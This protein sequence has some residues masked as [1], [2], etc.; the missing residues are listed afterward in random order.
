MPRAGAPL[1]C[2]P[3]PCPSLRGAISTPS[4]PDQKRRARSG[5]SAG[6]SMSASGMAA[7]ATPPPPG[8]LRRVRVLGQ[9]AEIGV[10]GGLDRVRGVVRLLLAVGLPGLLQ[11][12]LVAEPALA[13]K[14]RHC[15]LSL[16]A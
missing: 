8:R 6:N 14:L 2:H 13:L 10:V 12:A 9:A 11:G 4:S 7:D 1:D 15:G 5:S 3:S 16:A